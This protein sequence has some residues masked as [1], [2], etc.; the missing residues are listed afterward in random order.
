M[1]SSLV[2]AVLYAL[3]DAITSAAY[4]ALELLDCKDDLEQVTGEIVRA[5]KIPA[6]I[7]P[8]VHTEWI[9]FRTLLAKKPEDSIALKL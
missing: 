9:T 4:W 7:S 3:Y 8:K 6:V 2:N 1:I 5:N